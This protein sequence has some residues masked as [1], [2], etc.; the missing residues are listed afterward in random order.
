VR[1]GNLSQLREGLNAH[2]DFFV[3]WGI[4]L[5]LEKLQ[6]LTYRNL[7]KRVCVLSSHRRCYCLQFAGVRAVAPPTV[8]PLQFAGVRR[9]SAILTH[10][11]SPSLFAHTR[12]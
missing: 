2:Q 5:I 3:Q 12:T 6:M 1:L 11:L 10:F 9:W 7:F 8:L 4:L